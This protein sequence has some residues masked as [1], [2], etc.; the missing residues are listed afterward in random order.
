M[1]VNVFYFV[2]N[3]LHFFNFVTTIYNEYI[4]FN[5]MLKYS[6]FANVAKYDYLHYLI[7]RNVYIHYYFSLNI[8]KVFL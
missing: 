8:R 4:A 6:V 3:L 5:E 2:F 7:F 1:L